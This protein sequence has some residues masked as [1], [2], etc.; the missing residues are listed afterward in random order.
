MTAQRQPNFA[1]LGA[2]AIGTATVADLGRRGYRHLSL[3][4]VDDEALSPVIDSGQVHFAGLWGSGIVEIARATLDPAA[5]VPEADIVVVATTADAHPRVAET[6]AP[7]LRSGQIVLLHQGYVGGA[8]LFSQQLRR[9]GCTAE[10]QIAETVNALYLCA[11]PSPGSVYIKG[12][13]AWLEVAAYP[14]TQTD[15]VV[16]TLSAYFP[17]FASGANSLATGLNNPNPMVHPA[18]YLLNMSIVPAA[19]E[20][21]TKQGKGT[22]YFDEVLTR[23][24]Q[25][26][27][28]RLEQERLA[29]L[30][31]LGLPGITRAEFGRRC[32]PEGAVLRSNV[33]RF[34]PK[35]LPRFLYEDVPA[36]LVPIAV[37]ATVVGVATPVTSLLIDLA[38]LIAHE[39]F[40]ETG[41]SLERFGLKDAGAAEIVAAFA[42]A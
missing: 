34:G 30:D 26:I 36:G 11:R 27:S 39:D 23:P 38:S 12:L 28:E 6:L 15:E 33:P 35:L 37:L 5:I 22:L 2:G 24:I 20:G 1:I 19:G 4:D 31:A 29:L 18:A 10:L 42:G 7:L 13:K 3:C 21:V 41:R 8:F 25:E 16:A 14:Q 17:Q 40:W 32:Y 9:Y